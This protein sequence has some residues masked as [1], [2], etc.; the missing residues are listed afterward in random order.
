[1]MNFHFRLFQIFMATRKTS[2]EKKTPAGYIVPLSEA[3]FV[4]RRDGEDDG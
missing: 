1:M 3:W 4:R 2:K